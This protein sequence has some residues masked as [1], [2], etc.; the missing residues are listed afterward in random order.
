[1]R[2]RF[3]QQDVENPCSNVQEMQQR[4]ASHVSRCETALMRQ[5][6]TGTGSGDADMLSRR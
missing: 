5:Y 2:C 6:E 1:M 4:A 3:C